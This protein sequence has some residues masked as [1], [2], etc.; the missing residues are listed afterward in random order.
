VV[1]LLQRR[2][3]ASTQQQAQFVRHEL[4]F[5]GTVE[6]LLVN[7][8]RLARELPSYLQGQLNRRLRECSLHAASTSNRDEK[9]FL[10]SRAKFVSVKWLCELQV[11]PE[12][13]LQQRLVEKFSQS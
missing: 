11:W 5:W 13:L 6:P 3:V 4:S 10:K 8:E 2:F 12:K 7:F 1:L 9:L